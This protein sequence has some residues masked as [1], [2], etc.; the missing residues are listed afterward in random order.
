HLFF[1]RRTMKHTTQRWP[2]WA[3]VLALALAG[4]SGG[5]KGKPGAETGDPGFAGT[6]DCVGENG[7]GSTYQGKVKITK[8]GDTYQ[9]EW[10]I[11][12]QEAHVGVGI[13]EAGRL[14]S[15]WATVTGGVVTKGVVV[16]RKEGGKLVGRWAQY[17]GG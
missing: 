8:A 6:Y 13:V 17:P 11:G 5:D 15:S 10:L 14:C 9:L 3:T 1:R 16:Y 2:L 7:G 12:G 4:C